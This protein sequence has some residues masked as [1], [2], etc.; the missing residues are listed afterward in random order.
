[1]KDKFLLDIKDLQKNDKDIEK[2]SYESIINNL[3][4]KNIKGKDK[5]RGIDE[6]DTE[7]LTN[8]TLIPGNIYSFIYKANTATKY[9]DGTIQFEYYDSLPIVL[10]TNYNSKIIRGINLNLC[11]FALRTLILNTFY[12]IDPEFF[13]KTALQQAN[14]NQIPHSEKISKMLLTEQNETKILQYIKQQYNIQNIGIIYR[15]YNIQNIKS[16]RLIEIW[17][18]KYIPFLKYNQSIKQD[19]LNKIYEVINID[20]KHI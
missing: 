2:K 19:I 13:E 16:P 3:W 17:Q 12:N 11:N 10:I 7:S 8:K 5:A 9:N 18:W 15:T 6:Y 20:K 4:I 1:M 14:K